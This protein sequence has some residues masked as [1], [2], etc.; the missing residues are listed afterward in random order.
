VSDRT[1]R[2]RLPADAPLS[3]WLGLD[4]WWNQSV[5]L[6]KAHCP[7]LDAEAAALLDAV[8]ARLKT[9]SQVEALEAEDLVVAAA[10]SV[11]DAAAI[12]E[13]DR[14]L[15]RAAQQALGPMRLQPAE[16]D[17]VTQRTRE[18]VLV[19]APGRRSRLQSYSGRGPLDAWLRAVVARQALATVPQRP[20]SDSG[21]LRLSH[22]DP[23]PESQLKNAQHAAA[24]RAALEAAFAALTARQRTLLRLHGLDNL[25]LASIG[26]MYG[27]DASS[28]SRWLAAARA[29][30]RTDVAARLGQQLELSPSA[31]ESVLRSAGVASDVT[32]ER[33]LAGTSTR[34]SGAATVRGP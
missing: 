1:L 16:V 6:V 13:V 10:A 7:G 28:V 29:A 12:A 19:G 30:V 18:L 25:S 27:K 33:L 26:A 17:E 15:T 9:F 32:L 14:R 34:D 22:P 20:G 3:T 5:A 4:D 21:V 31:V 2:A 24:V 11:G 8:A 23:G